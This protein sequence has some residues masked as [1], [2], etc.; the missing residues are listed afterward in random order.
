MSN[1]KFT[2]T[3]PVARWENVIQ[4][5]LREVFPYSEEQLAD[6]RDWLDAQL[7]VLEMQFHSFVTPRSQKGSLGR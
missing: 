3:T 2:P 5:R 4:N 1:K 6:F 7:L